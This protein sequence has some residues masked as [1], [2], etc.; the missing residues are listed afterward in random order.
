VRALVLIVLAVICGVLAAVAGVAAAPG[1]ELG[2]VPAARWR[3]V[4][5]GTTVPHF[6]AV[7]ALSSRGVWA[8]GAI[9]EDPRLTPVAAHWDG[10]SLNVMKPFGPSVRGALVGVVAL[11]PDDVWAVG[12]L[13]TGRPYPF[14]SRG[15]IVHWDGGG[16]R[17]VA[18]PLL[19]PASDLADVT[20]TSDTD[21]WVAGSAVARVRVANP[22]A[23]GTVRRPLLLHWDGS[24]WRR[25][26][27]SPL[28]QQCPSREY[29]G[30]DYFWHWFCDTSIDAIDAAARDDVWAA[31]TEW[32]VDFAGFSTTLLH[33]DGAAWMASRSPTTGGG[34]DA[35]DVD[36]TAPGEAWMLDEF[37]DASVYSEWRYRLIHWTNGRARAF[38]Y[39]TREN[40]SVAAIA[41]V[42]NRSVWIVG[43][44]WGDDAPPLVIHWNGKTAVRQ[45]SALDSQ[46]GATLA[47][48][49]ALSPT[50]I[51]AAG[52]H[53]LARYSP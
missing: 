49:T 17:R 36:A 4:A 13:D 12:S 51:W 23:S 10:R 8:V 25:D 41:A 39:Q 5:S 3:A 31:G 53:L 30:A 9:G 32:A 20:A 7:A 29:D 43:E 15:V 34:V 47:A 46:R 1:H 16:W 33:S 11:A 35:L 40:E 14:G 45:R 6:Q 21:V 44:R 27:V 2:A 26:D 37:V 50:E 22:A 19:P 18:T 38:E 52:Y 48:L 28:V 42:S 24:R